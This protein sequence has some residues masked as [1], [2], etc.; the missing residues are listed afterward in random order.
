MNAWP[1]L[2]LTTFAC[3]QTDGIVQTDTSPAGPRVL[4]LDRSKPTLACL[5]ADG[6]VIENTVLSGEGSLRAALMNESGTRL[7]AVYQPKGKDILSGPPQA[8]WPRLVVIDSVEMKVIA[9]HQLGP[10]TPSLFLSPSGAYLVA[11]WS[12]LQSTREIPAVSAEFAVLNLAD[13]QVKWRATLERHATVYWLPDETGVLLV[14]PE[15]SQRKINPLPGEIRIFDTA[16][17]KL[18][19]TFPHLG[20]DFGLTVSP[21]QQTVFLRESNKSGQWQGKVVSRA[22]WA[23][24]DPLVAGLN[25]WLVWVDPAGRQTF[26]YGEVMAASP[27]QPFKAEIRMIRAGEIAAKTSVPFYPWFFRHSATR[28]QLWVAGRKN[29]VC[30]DPTSLKPKLE[31]EVEGEEPQGFLISPDNQYGALL[32]GKDKVTILDLTKGTTVA[33]HRFGR[34]LVKIA[35]AWAKAAYSYS[36]YDRAHAHILS[37]YVIRWPEGA[38][39]TFAPGRN[40]ILALNMYTHD[41]TAIE[42]S[43]GEVLERTATCSGDT[44]MRLAGEKLLVIEPQCMHIMDPLTLRPVGPWLHKSI[45]G[46]AAVQDGSGVVVFTSAESVLV[47]LNSG[48][49]GARIT[50]DEKTRKMVKET[51][52]LGTYDLFVMPARVVKERH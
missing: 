37:P 46:Y 34:M 48:Q 45:V 42:A 20:K 7:V 25:N 36:L 52:S 19:K 39:L 11:L 13:G 43:T 44:L 31:I 4:F 8:R 17:G 21:D 16:T 18:M 22:D 32:C 49:E 50:L 9:Q 38:Q 10:I 2:L 27:G 23:A 14:F 30:L 5:Q 40:V 33:S 6:R 3:F 41:I 29:L 15:E 24:A 35:I 1:K 28:D 26:L 47:D 51:Y 12:S